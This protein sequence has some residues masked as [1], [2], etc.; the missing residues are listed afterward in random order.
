MRD[1][2]PKSIKSK[3]IKTI[4]FDSGLILLQFM[5]TSVIYFKR[6]HTMLILDICKSHLIY[7][8]NTLSRIYNILY[9]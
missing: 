8:S 9:S 7:L 5:T 6:E 1:S 2:Y 3:N 4:E